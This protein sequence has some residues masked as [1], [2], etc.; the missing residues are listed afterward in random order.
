MPRFSPVK[1]ARVSDNITAQLKNAILSGDF[2]PEEKLPSER[3]LT[4][5]FQASRVVVRE[6]I[7]NLELN[8]FVSIRQGPHGGAYVQQLGFDRLTDMYTDLFMSGELSVKEIMQARIL[9]E[10][11]AVRLAAQRV[12]GRWADKLKKA[13]AEEQVPVQKHAEWVRRNM[14]TDAVL[15]AMC[16]NR[17]YQ[18]ILEPLMKL[19]QEIVIVVKPERTIIHDAGEHRQIVDAVLQGDGDRA[20]EAMRRHIAN[21]GEK[22]AG[23][24][25]AYRRRKGLAARS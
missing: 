3:E 7:R 8:G 9:I 25:D 6:A 1:S 18:A 14:A 4:E 10:P 11:E 12:T 22:L 16:G 19:T 17:F 24:E 2:K 23:L 13:L 20:A 5:T 21:V 15:I